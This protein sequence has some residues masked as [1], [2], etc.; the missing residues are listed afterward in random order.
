MISIN[1]QF[2]NKISIKTLILAR[3]YV[4]RQLREYEGIAGLPALPVPA[5]S[6]QEYCFAVHSQKTCQCNP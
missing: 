5:C 3:E 4:K 6:N 1:F 2:F